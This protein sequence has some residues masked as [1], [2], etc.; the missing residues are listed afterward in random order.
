MSKRYL[1]LFVGLI[2][3]LL[4]ACGG[5]TPQEVT[6]DINMTEYAFAPENLEFKVGQE[7]TLNLINSGQ[8]VHE[9][10]FGRQVMK[11]DNRPAGYMEDM[12]EVGG[13]EPEVHMEEE[14][15]HE[16]EEEMHEGFMV[17]IPENGTGTMKFTVT[18]EMLGEWEMGCF[19]QD[20]VHYDAGM[21]GRV[22][23]TE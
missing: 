14:A 9:I 20:G 11:M 19:E 5:S 22:T 21:K 23:V 10:M 12:F 8:L 2:A 1:V 13:V 3:V 6:Y 7:V 15:E 18:K 4:A 17:V 16:H